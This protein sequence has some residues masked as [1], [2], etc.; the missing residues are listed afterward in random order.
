MQSRGG[1]R[2]SGASPSRTSSTGQR[3]ALAP[4]AMSRSR[5][6]FECPAGP[7]VAGWFL[8]AKPPAGFS[9]L[10]Q[11]CDGEGGWRRGG[12]AARGAARAC[13]TDAGGRALC[14]SCGAW[15]G[16]VRRP[17]GRTIG[18][19]P[20]LLAFHNPAR[21]A[22]LAAGAWLPQPRAGAGAP[23]SRA[24]WLPRTPAS[25]W[26]HVCPCLF[27][28]EPLGRVTA[29]ALLA[30]RPRHGC[31][32]LCGQLPVAM[33]RDC[34]WSKGGRQRRWRWAMVLSM[35]WVRGRGAGRGARCTLGCWHPLLASSVRRA[36]ADVAHAL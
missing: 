17:D 16:W 22:I 21:C 6:R 30:P 2:P 14:V 26:A 29:E 24:Q 34:H 3:R 31:T 27:R 12:G 33:G 7:P 32:A 20:A 19:D 11:R 25:H 18:Q 13:G 15:A 10:K 28:A 23:A 9:Q 1:A 4:R 36:E 8:Y 5:S 35:V